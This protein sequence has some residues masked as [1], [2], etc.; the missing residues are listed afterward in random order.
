MYEFTWQQLLETNVVFFV[1]VFALREFQRDNV[2]SPG[3]IPKIE[4]R[5]G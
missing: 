4:L 2:F 1:S 5:T 3:V